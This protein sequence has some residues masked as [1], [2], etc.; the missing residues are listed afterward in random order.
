MTIGVQRAIDPRGGMQPFINSFIHSFLYFLFGMYY[1][2]QINIRYQSSKRGLTQHK[3]GVKNSCTPST[4]HHKQ[5][6][7]YN[8]RTAVFIKLLWGGRKRGN[9]RVHAWWSCVIPLPEKSIPGTPEYTINPLVFFLVV[10]IRFLLYT[11]LHYVH[12]MD[13]MNDTPSK[14]VR[15]G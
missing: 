13:D 2:V 10:F 1:L 5:Q 14:H 11:I 15:K 4:P 8:T 9:T 3:E 12:D 6:R 7:R